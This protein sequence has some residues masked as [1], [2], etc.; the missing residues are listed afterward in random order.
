MNQVGKPDAASRTSGL[1][2]GDKDSRM[3]SAGE[4]FAIC[5]R[6]VLANLPARVHVGKTANMK[7]ELITRFK[8]V[9]EDGGVIELVVWRVPRSVPPTVHGYKYRAVRA[10]ARYRAVRD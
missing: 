10:I 4:K 2:S 8:R 9:A 1:M 6:M 3:P 7:A 5:A